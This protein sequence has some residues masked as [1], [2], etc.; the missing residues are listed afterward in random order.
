MADSIVSSVLRWLRAGYPEGVPPKDYYPLLALLRDRLS[1]EEFD[2]VIRR[3]DSLDADPVRV[4]VIRAAIEHVTAEPPHDDD[5]RTVAGRLAAA[6]WPLSGGARKLAAAHTAENPAAEPA[7]PTHGPVQRALAWL[8][9]GYPEGIPATDFVPVLAVLRTRL[10]DDQ[11][12][13]VADQL[14]AQDLERDGV[15]SRVDAQILM[16]RLLGELPSD[17]DLRR[18]ERRL[19]ESGWNLL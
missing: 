2:E 10:N 11:V 18:V 4:S 9:A 7:A 17:D 16:T 15:V 6:G 13:E 5:V 3:I 1:S 8:R 19:A 14:I 12:R